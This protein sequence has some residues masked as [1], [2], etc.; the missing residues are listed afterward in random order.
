MFGMAEKNSDTNPEGEKQTPWSD[1][2]SASIG[3]AR[4]K[5]SRLRSRTKTNEEG[6]SKPS[7]GSG[8][9]RADLEKVK[10]MFDPKAWRTLVKTPF[11]LGK[12]LTGRSCWDLEKEEEDTLATTTAA[13]AEYFLQSDPKWVCLSICAFNW[14]VIVTSKFLANAV[15]VKR[16]QEVLNNGHHPDRQAA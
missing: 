8:L 14:A 9:S 7:T 3:E 15:E 16:E 6:T 4:A 11:V 13:S 2:L 12:V 1:S 10:M 5:L